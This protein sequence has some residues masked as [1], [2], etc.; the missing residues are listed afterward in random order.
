MN[1]SSVDLKIFGVEK[2]FQQQKVKMLDI[3]NL[4]KVNQLKKIHRK[5]I[6]KKKVELFQIL[7]APTSKL[8]KIKYMWILFFLQMCSTHKKSKCGKTEFIS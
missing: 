4:I 6:Y 8:A 2:K 1:K 5:K 7:K 3:Y